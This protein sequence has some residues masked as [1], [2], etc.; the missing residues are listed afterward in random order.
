MQFH[1]S[2]SLPACGSAELSG[3]ELPA[4]LLPGKTQ[5]HLSFAGICGPRAASVHTVLPPVPSPSAVTVCLVHQA[6]PWKYHLHR[7]CSGSAALGR[8]RDTL[9]IWSFTFLIVLKPISWFL[10]APADQQGLCPTTL[11]EGTAGQ[12]GKK[13]KY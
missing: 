5:K 6:F 4:P 12:G 2:T 10:S 8:G 1:S 11:I 13:V 3:A 7:H 9:D